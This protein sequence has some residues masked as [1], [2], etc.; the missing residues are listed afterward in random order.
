MNGLA[1]HEDL[2]HVLFMGALYSPQTAPDIQQLL[3]NNQER[4]ME[5]RVIAPRLSPRRFNKLWIE[6]SAVNN[7]RETLVEQA[8]NMAR[9]TRL[10]KGPLRSGDQ[11]KITGLT[12]GSTQIELNGI[13]LGHIDHPE[14]FNLLLRVWIGSVPLSSKFREQLLTDDVIDTGLLQQFND[15][16]PDA[17][18]NGIIAQWHAPDLPQSEPQTK[19]EIVAKTELAVAPEIKATPTKPT[20]ASPKKVET[21]TAEPTRQETVAATINEPAPEQ[22]D[23]QDEEAIAQALLAQQL[24][25]SELIRKTYKHVSY[26]S[27]AVD[28]GQQG[29]VRVEV[30]VDRSG[31]ITGLKELESSRY[32]LLNK[33]A[34]ASVKKAAPFPSIPE[35]MTGEQFKFT[36]PIVF[37]LQ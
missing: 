32:R 19:P 12:T 2:N 13:T 22:D 4:Q 28:R 16:Q 29:N 26:P 25:Q 27:R 18:R 10:F 3:D 9:F 5:L 36:L 30:T 6:G 21:T 7:P 1:I 33:A 34:V 8:R 24:Y 11:V 20:L 31:R 17:N 14:F 15:V 23:T 37:R 35:S